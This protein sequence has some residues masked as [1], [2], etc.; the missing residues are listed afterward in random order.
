MSK[1]PDETN[2]TNTFQIPDELVK[3]IGALSEICSLQEDSAAAMLYRLMFRHERN[4]DLLDRY[5]DQIL[6]ALVGF[7]GENAEED[8]RN[9]LQYLQAV[10]PSEVSTHKEFFENELKDITDENFEDGK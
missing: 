9:Y 5:A 10:L 2:D 6:D 3:S 7:G 1:T 8:Y 4:I